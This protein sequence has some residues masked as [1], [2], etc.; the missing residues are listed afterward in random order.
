MESGRSGSSGF[1]ISKHFRPLEV[2]NEG[3]ENYTIIFIPFMSMEISGNA[4]LHRVMVKITYIGAISTNITF[5]G[6]IS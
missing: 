6:G 2:G 3:L 1:F 5:L 4:C